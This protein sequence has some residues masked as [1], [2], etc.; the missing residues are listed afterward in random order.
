MA[1]NLATS[2]PEGWDEASQ[3]KIFRNARAGSLILQIGISERVHPAYLGKPI[4][5]DAKGRVK[6]RINDK[7]VRDNGGSVKVRVVS[8]NPKVLDQVVRLWEA[9]K[10]L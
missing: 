10:K 6:L 3:Y 8:S 7:D 1:L 9:F 4:V 5:A 2:G